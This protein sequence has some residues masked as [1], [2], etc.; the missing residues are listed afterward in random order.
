[1]KLSQLA[2]PLFS[3]AR[4]LAQAARRSGLSETLARAAHAG[5]ARTSHP[6]GK[7]GLHIAGGVLDFA[8]SRG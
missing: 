6:F 1:M 8:N 3:G 7:L 5:A 4:S 2:Q